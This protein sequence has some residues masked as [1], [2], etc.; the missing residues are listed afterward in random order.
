MPVEHTPRDWRKPPCG[1]LLLLLRPL[2]R[3][4]SPGTLCLCRASALS[5]LKRKL[6]LLLKRIVCSLLPASYS[7]ESLAVGDRTLPTVHHTMTPL[8][9]FSFSNTLAFLI[10][11]TK[12]PLGWDH[13]R[14]R[15]LKL[16]S[17][18]LSGIGM[19]ECDWS[20]PPWT[21]VPVLLLNRLG[22][23]HASDCHL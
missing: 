13:W 19:K 14:S 16:H 1:A 3:C 8:R 5:P 23:H 21:W 17:L 12:K 20:R 4:E 22:T 7:L 10:L 18:G 11:S 6:I 2:Q 15:Q 9:S